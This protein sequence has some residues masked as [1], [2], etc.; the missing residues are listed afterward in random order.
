MKAAYTPEGLILESSCHFDFSGTASLLHLANRSLFIATD[1][2]F[3][4]STDVQ[5]ESV[6]LCIC[7]IVT[8]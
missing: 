6:L 1:L 8:G 5:I 3:D 7:S 2:C 4:F